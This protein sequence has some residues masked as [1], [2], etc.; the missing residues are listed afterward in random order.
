MMALRE[1]FE[2]DWVVFVIFIQQRD[3]LEDLS[4]QLL[5]FWANRNKTDSGYQRPSF[6]KQ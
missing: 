4:Y 2:D 3:L 1:D 5:A 6:Q